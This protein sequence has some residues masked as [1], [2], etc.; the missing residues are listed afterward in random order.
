MARPRRELT[1]AEIIRIAT[2]ARR[3]YVDDVSKSD[4]AEE[5]GVNRFKIAKMLDEAR[6]RGIIQFVI[7][8]PAE[9]DSSLSDELADANGLKDALVVKGVEDEDATNLRAALGQAAASFLTDKLRPGDI[10]G[11]AAGR[12]IGALSASVLRLPPCTT[13]ALTGVLPAASMSTSSIEQLRRMSIA[14]DGPAYP[15][16]TPWLVSDART[17]AALRREPEVSEA[18]GRHDTLTIAVVA[19]GSWNPPDSTLYDAVTEPERQA[20]RA[21][22]VAAEFAGIFVDSDGVVVETELVQ[23]MIAISSGQLRAVPFVLAVAGGSNKHQAISAALR[24]GYIH[25]IVTDSGTARALVR[26]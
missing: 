22:D 3:H 24:S 14:A 19:I 17:A 7:N 10:L 23:R 21:K 20:L 12:T 11:L 18:L 13:V 5:L 25:S 15:I 1:Q 6:A 8:M 2:V 9:L 16:Y 4:L 26:A